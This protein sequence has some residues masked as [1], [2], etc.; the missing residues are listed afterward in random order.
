MSKIA[1]S[2]LL[3]FALAMLPAATRA[4]PP[5]PTDIAVAIHR[6]GEVYVVD[7]DFAVQA[8][9]REVWDVLTDYDHMADFVSNV[10]ASRIVRR[11]P[12]KMEVEQ[13]SRLGFGPFQLKFEN[14]REIEF[15][16][17]QEIHSTLIRGDMKA[18]SFTTRLVAEGAL[19]GSPITAGSRRIA[20]SP[21]SSASPFSKARRGRSSL[22][23]APRSCGA[24]SAAPPA[25]LSAFGI[26]AGAARFQR[27]TLNSLSTLTSNSALSFGPPAATSSIAR[28]PA[29]RPGASARAVNASGV[30][31][32]E[33]WIFC[34]FIATQ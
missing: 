16:P 15:I 8:T 17:L 5:D 3:S 32:P 14:A 2:L 28:R 27:A 33:Y 1:S 12:Q 29:S 4:A 9:P 20:G 13:I 34:P 19:P 31:V 30:A 24:S 26:R 18:S 25:R 21:R 7:V 23:S 11:D 22:S 10:A 6:D